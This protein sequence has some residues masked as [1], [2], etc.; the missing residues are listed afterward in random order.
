MTLT[1]KM[2]R[3]ARGSNWNSYGWA[4]IRILCLGSSGH[5]GYDVW[6]LIRIN[7]LIGIKP[8]GREGNIV[9]IVTQ[10]I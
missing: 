4:L 5:I 8:V 1:A 2:K 3:L 10:I 7:I 6:A 9:Y